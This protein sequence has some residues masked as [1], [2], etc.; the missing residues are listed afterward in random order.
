MEGN[1]IISSRLYQNS[2][3]E[4][5]PA[6]PKILNGDAFAFLGAKKAACSSVQDGIDT[7]VIQS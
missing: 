1:Q 7:E 3:S 2:A 4:V 6:G 5:K